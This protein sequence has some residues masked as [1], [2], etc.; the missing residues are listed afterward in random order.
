[1][2]ID[3]ETIKKYVINLDRRS[4]RLE[5]FLEECSKFFGNTDV[6]RVSGIE[7]DNG[8]PANAQPRLCIALSF[9]K[10]MKLAIDAGHEHVLIM[11]DDCWFPSVNAR[12]YADT[13]FKDVCDNVDV[14]AGGIYTSAG[15]EPT[16]SKNWLRTKE[17]SGTHFMVYNRKAMYK[18]L[19][20][21]FSKNIFHIDR[22]LARPT[23]LL[24]AGLTVHVAAQFFAL[25]KE[26]F[27]D[28]VGKQTHYEKLLNRFNLLP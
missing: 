6:E 28:N 7:P 22:F 2:K 5:I 3:L 9:Q 18:I 19:S 25:Q 8:A 10:A 17:C 4:D 14:L 21:D 1:M 27:S 16:G 26:G 11:E 24:G 15:L 23:E 12:T 20:E 13:C